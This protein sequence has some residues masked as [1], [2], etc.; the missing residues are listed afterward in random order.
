MA[1]D[2]I[3]MTPERHSKRVMHTVSAIL[4]P[5][6]KPLDERP[7]LL[8]EE[9]R[10]EIREMKRAEKTEMKAGNRRTRGIWDERG[11]ARSRE[12]EVDGVPREGRDGVEEARTL[13]KEAQDRVIDAEATVR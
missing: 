9:K 4:V 12:D 8:S 11:R 2:I 6:G 3:T 10:V 7:P 13:G 5:F 1:G